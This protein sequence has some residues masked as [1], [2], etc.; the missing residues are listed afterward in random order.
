MADVSTGQEPTTATQTDQAGTDSAAGEKQPE[1]GKI[2][3]AIESAKGDPVKLTALLESLKSELGD[4]RKEA[5]TYRTSKKEIEQQLEA[6]KAKE[7][8]RERAELSELERVKLEKQDLEKKY[9][10]SESR[11]S[12]AE[13]KSSFV[14]AGTTDVDSVLLYWGALSAEE[15]AKT[16][17]D[18]FATELKAKKS[19]LFA[20]NT[21]KDDKGSKPPNPRRDQ[22]D[23]DSSETVIPLRAK[24]PAEKKARKDAWKQV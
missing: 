13:A 21:G 1:K 18:K 4:T 3:K 24:T 5:A 23:K 22:V 17:P 15:K 10:E 9:A 19:H 6:Y 8:E 11:A 14:A 16:T 20:G 7:T 12:L 2:D